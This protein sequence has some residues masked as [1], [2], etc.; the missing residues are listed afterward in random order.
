MSVGPRAASCHRRAERGAHS[1][2]DVSDPTPE[3][4]NVVQIAQET[5]KRTLCSIC[6]G[7]QPRVPC[8]K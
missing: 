6:R 1:D 2:T 3:D 4:G 7:W 5:L 8:H